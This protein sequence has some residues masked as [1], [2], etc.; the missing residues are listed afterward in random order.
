MKNKILKQIVVE[1]VFSIKKQ[2]LMENIKK[3]HEYVTQ[4][5]YNP[6][7]KIREPWPDDKKSSE[8]LL[9][10]MGAKP[11]ALGLN[12]HGYELDTKED[13]FWFYEDGSVYS[14]GQ[15]RTL[16]YET[17]NGVI[18]L[19]NE[20][21]LER[22]KKTA[23][24][25]GKI[26]MQGG[27]PVLTL[28]KENAIKAEPKAKKE[29]P[30]TWI[31]YLQTVMDWL[32][33]IPGY[34]DIIDIIN[35]SIYAARGKYFDAFFSVI[36]VIPIIGSVIKVTAKSI[37]KGARLAKLEKLIRAS[38]KGS[39][40]ISAQMKMWDE[41]VETGVIKPR[42]LAKIG[43]GLESLESVL[44]SSYSTIKKAPIS[45][46]AA[47][48]II[49][50]LDDFANWLRINGKSIEELANAKKVGRK[51]SF[52]SVTDLT[53][54]SAKTLK[55]IEKI[56]KTTST[57][58]LKL[59]GMKWFPENKVAQ[60]AKGLERRFKREMRDPLKLTALTKT[61]PTTDFSTILKLIERQLSPSQL[62]YVRSLNPT[63]ATDIQI[64]FR[65][66]QNE[67]TDVY[68]K[69]ATTVI[70]R[71]IK[72]NS[73][74]FNTFKTNDLNNLK[75]VLS[76]DMIPAGKTIFT[77]INLS[78]RKS[79]DIIWNEIHDVL[80]SAGLEWDGTSLPTEN[81]IDAADGVV[82]PALAKAVSEFFPGVYETTV[83]TSDSIKNFITAIGADKGLQGASELMKDKSKDPF[84]PKA[85]G[86][87]K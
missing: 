44:R 73:P 47:D 83:E 1:E 12:P 66:L 53:G 14:T 55:Q 50:Q 2:I 52:K 23:W 59:R 40:D 65:Y 10:Q 8:D 70:N 16:G 31:D 80:E 11:F 39:D 34:G 36:A 9:K 61:L 82:W 78:T 64:L 57:I 30:N 84:K 15:I 25:V 37:Y 29:Q 13:R 6:T 32:G 27:K 43:N 54:A 87:Y 48:D 42:D 19:W 38:F 60:I 46:K 71:S 75:T 35:A 77:D 67:A 3:L 79:L 45:N 62:S 81:K 49:Q 22:H 72:T 20:P 21:H 63:S 7:Y 74:I 18:V 56:N 24:K 76:R 28:S 69:V 85:S 58:M 5:K 41:L 4:S 68:N 26:S 51:T 86:T 33:F 17:K